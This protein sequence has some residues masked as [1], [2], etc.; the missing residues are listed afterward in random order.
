MLLEGLALRSI[1]GAAQRYDT[2][3]PNGG[4]FFKSEGA[5]FTKTKKGRQAILLTTPNGWAFYKVRGHQIFLQKKNKEAKQFYSLLQRDMGFLRAPLQGN[6][7][8]SKQVGVLSYF[9]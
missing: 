4:G 5:L 8:D 1:P 6:P 2:S 3:T 7:E 9:V